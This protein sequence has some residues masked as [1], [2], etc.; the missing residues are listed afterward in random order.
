[1]KNILKVGIITGVGLLLA[2]IIRWKT[3]TEMM[4]FQL[5]NPRI[6]SVD[7]QGIH[8]R[9][10]IAVQNPSK[11]KVRVT[12]P[13]I[14]LTTNGKFLANSLPQN[15]EFTIEPLTTSM[16]DTIEIILSWTALGSYTI[17]IITKFSQV[18]AAFVNKDLRKLGSLLGIPLEMSYTLYS[19]NILIKSQPQKLL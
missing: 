11:I 10:E 3:S 13:V 2:K 1:M 9:T 14:T 16:I 6:H 19:G 18:K 17:N 5:S 4:N 7:L 8:F 15:K 12:K